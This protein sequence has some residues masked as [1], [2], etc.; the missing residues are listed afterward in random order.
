MTPGK[1]HA[2][3]SKFET[4]LQLPPDVEDDQVDEIGRAVLI[5]QARARKLTV[6]GG[7]TRTAD[8]LVVG[9]YQADEAGHTVLTHVPIGSPLAEG[10]T[11]VEARVVTW[12]T[13][14]Q[15]IEPDPAAK[16]AG[17]PIDGM[18][19]RGRIPAEV[20]ESGG[21]VSFRHGLDSDDVVIALYD[22]AGTP[23]GYE[24]AVEIDSNE[25]QVLVPRGAS[26]IEA[27]VDSNE[28]TS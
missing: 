25:Q 10:K 4:T 2:P 12:E 5:E 24:F 19:S 20:T 9:V 3:V 14:V 8:N 15:P 21:M 17:E 28:E 26:K 13:D 23:L 18:F 1:D 7:V 16:I 6:I 22:V 27:R 11:E